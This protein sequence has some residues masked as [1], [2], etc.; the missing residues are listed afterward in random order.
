MKYEPVDLKDNKESR[1]HHYYKIFTTDSKLSKEIKY[2][3]FRKVW[4]DRI[5]LSYAVTESKS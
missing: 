1:Y 2:A 4:E 3:D 5:E